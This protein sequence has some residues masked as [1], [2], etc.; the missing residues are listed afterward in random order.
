MIAEGVETEAQLALLAAE[1]CNYYQGFLCS[2]PI[3]VT[4]LTKLVIQGCRKDGAAR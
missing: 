2:Q 3:D 1:G 4:A